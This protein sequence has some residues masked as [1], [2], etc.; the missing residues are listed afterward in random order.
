MTSTTENNPPKGEYQE[1]T[2]PGRSAESP[3][4]AWPNDRLS[5][6]ALVQSCGGDPYQLEKAAE[7]CLVGIRWP[8][9]IRCPQPECGSGDVREVANRKPMPYRCRRCRKH[10]SATSGTTLRSAKLSS[11][12]VLVALYLL[13]SHDPGITAVQLADYLEIDEKTARRLRKLF[14]TV[15]A[16]ASSGP[17]KVSVEADQAHGSGSET[18]GHT[19]EHRWAPDLETGEGEPQTTDHGVAN[20]VD[21][22]ALTLM[23]LG[24]LLY[25]DRHVAYHVISGLWRKPLNRNGVE[26][27]GDDAPTTGTEPS[28][29]EVL[30]LLDPLQWI[31]GEPI[32]DHETESER[33]SVDQPAS[34]LTG[35]RPEAAAAKSGQP[36]QRSNRRKPE[37]LPLPGADQV[38]V[39]NVRAAPTKRT[40]LRKP[41]RPK[42]KTSR[43]R[44]LQP[45][46]PLS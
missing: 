15:M 25:G 34:G 6:G 35:R 22:L 37:S 3:Q 12:K 19:D 36:D 40:K 26:C 39:L 16:D 24:I 21:P 20:C 1:P 27:A 28:W 46:L 11:L 7:A 9:G 45:R 31:P 10:F 5:F 33:E 30:R 23:A 44:P 4:Q 38:K 13:A 14:R 8:D 32:K 17:L 43:V 41:G 2:A 18:N 42:K 29:S